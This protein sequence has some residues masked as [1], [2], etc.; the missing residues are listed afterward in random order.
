MPLEILAGIRPGDPGNLLRATLGNKVAAFI[1]TLGAEID[2]MVCGSYHIHIMLDD[3]NGVSL[4]H[5]AVKNDKELVD[6]IEVQAC[7]GFIQ[8]VHCSPG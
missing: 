7:S 8:Y 3:D 6:I 4:I 5:Q 2:D 1:S